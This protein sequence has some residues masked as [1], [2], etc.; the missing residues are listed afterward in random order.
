MPIPSIDIRSAILTALTDSVNGFNAR[1]AALASEYSWPNPYTIDFSPGSCAFFQGYLIADTEEWNLSQLSIFP[2]MSLYTK[3]DINHNREKFTKFAGDIT[4]CM[5]LF[6]R[7][8]IAGNVNSLETDDTDT[9]IDISRQALCD[10]LDL[11]AAR[12]GTALL[13]ANIAFQGGTQFVRSPLVLTGDGRAQL[14]H[15]EMRFAVRQ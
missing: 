13:P 8:R 14:L 15:C 4:V 1:L 6:I 10:S 11:L 3:D 12:T 2:A 5:D 9:V 7:F